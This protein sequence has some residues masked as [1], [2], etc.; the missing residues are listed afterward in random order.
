MQTMKSAVGL[1]LFLSLTLGLYAGGQENESF[2]S[3]SHYVHL[4]EGDELLMNVQIWGQVKN[5]G[6]YSLPE[7]SDIAILLSLAGGPTENADLSAVKV[8]RK[9][10]EK[11]SLF[12]INLKRCLL[13]G[14]KSK[15]IMKPGD[16]IEVMPSKFYSL[17][18]FIRF[19]TQISMVIVIYNQLFGK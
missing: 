5:P 11:D 10:V 18:N 19:I 16:I 8:I 4:G 12:K 7:N 14:E 9:G 2:Q 17:S 6:L 3:A 15:T 1:L 13:G